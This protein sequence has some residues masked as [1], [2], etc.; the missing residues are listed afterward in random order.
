MMK[1]L[2]LWS[3]CFS[4]IFGQYFSSINI[5]IVVRWRFLNNK[6]N[7]LPKYLR[8]IVKNL[9]D[10]CWKASI[11]NVW[12]GCP[13][14]KCR[15][16]PDRANSPKIPFLWSSFLPRC[17]WL[18]LE[19]QHSYQKNQ[20]PTINIKGQHQYQQSKV[21]INRN[22]SINIKSESI[23]WL[24]KLNQMHCKTKIFALNCNL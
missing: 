20:Q 7:W 3:M 15:K 19:E 8:R 11:S 5:L 21:I 23:S 1:V 24:S 22:I 13:V 9:V 16:S 14:Q 18:L 17:Q 2:L 6:R 10:V 4:V 12:Q